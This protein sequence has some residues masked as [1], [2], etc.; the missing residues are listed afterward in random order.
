[1]RAELKDLDKNQQIQMKR[2]KILR[3]DDSD[4]SIAKSV[5]IGIAKIAKLLQVIAPEFFVV[6]GDRYEAF[7][8]ASASMFTGVPIAHI[9]GGEITQGLLDDP[10]R[11]SISKMASLHLVSHPVHK[12]R[13][14]NMGEQ[15][16]SIY[17]VGGF[18]VDLVSRSSLLNYEEV[19]RFLGADFPREYFVVTFHPLTNDPQP[20]E[21][22]LDGLLGALSKVSRDIGL[23]FT[24]TNADAGGMALRAELQKFVDQNSN[25]RYVENLGAVRYLSTLKHSLGVIG[26]SSSGI[27]EAPYLGVPTLNIGTRQKGRARGASVIDVNSDEA[28]VLKGLEKLLKFDIRKLPESSVRIF[29]ESGASQEAFQILMNWKPKHKSSK[30]FFDRP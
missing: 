26:N 3:R 1:M 21:N 30:E 12:K 27:L 28:S 5:S 11:H 9:H 16:D 15:P 14:E 2:I 13:L 19:Q 10:M 22:Q 4:V 20:I 8:G 29:G 7:A 17:V 25:A 23:L 6:L 18:G 24:G